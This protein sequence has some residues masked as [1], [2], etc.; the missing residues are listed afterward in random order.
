MRLGPP[1]D[2]T[3]DKKWR[4]KMDLSSEIADRAPT[5]D[6]QSLPADSNIR[7]EILWRMGTGTGDRRALGV[8][9]V[10]SMHH[11][12]IRRRGDSQ[13]RDHSVELEWTTGECLPRN[14]FWSQRPCG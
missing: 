14:P 9:E 11:C 12:V 8:P 2:K 7:V 10:S 13:G 1:A 4:T 6:L 3:A 5:P